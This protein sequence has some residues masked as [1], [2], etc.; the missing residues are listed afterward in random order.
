MNSKNHLEFLI[1]ASRELSSLTEEVA[2]FRYTSETLIRIADGGVT[3]ISTFDKETA[4]LECRYIKG[5]GG[6][7]GKVL[8]ILKQ[9]IVGMRLP[10]NDEAYSGLM[11]SRLHTIEGGLH[12]LALGSLPKK[13][14]L[15]IERL[16]KLQSFYSL[17]IVE[18]NELLGS[19]TL[20]APRPLQNPSLV[21]AFIQQAAPTFLRIRATDALMKANNQ[22][23][24]S[25]FELLKAEKQL[26]EKNKQLEAANQQLEATNQQFEAANRQLEATNQQFEATNQQIEATNQQL[27]TRNLE[28]QESRQQI[29]ENQRLYERV[30][31]NIREALII[32]DGRHILFANQAATRY[33]DSTTLKGQD[34]FCFVAPKS[35]EMISENIRKRLAGEKVPDV[36][37]AEIMTKS[38]EMVPVE[39]SVAAISYKAKKAFLVML[40]DLSEREKAIREKA[41]LQKQLL[42]SQKMEAIATLAGGM[43]HDLNNIL[44]VIK[45]HAQLTLM[46]HVESDNLHEDM[47]QIM[48][49]A[50]RGAD[51]TRQLLLYSRRQ[52]MNYE[53]LNINDRV[54][55]LMKLLGRLIGED[56]KVTTKLSAELWD[57]K[58][59]SGNIDQ[60]I[61]NLTVNARDAM[62]EGGE[63]ILKT[64]N[65]RIDEKYLQSYTYAKVGEHVCLE[66]EDTGTGMDEETTARIFEP[67]FTTKSTGKGTGLGMSVVYGIVKEHGGWINVYSEPGRGS[68]FKVYLP[69]SLHKQ[70]RKIQN[71][72]NVEISP[73]NGENILLVEDEE[74]VLTSTRKLL[75][76]SGYQITVAT[77]AE[78]ALKIFRQR[79]RDFDLV[80]TDTILPGRTGL[81]LI[82]D[83]HAINPNI[84]VLVCSGYTGERIQRE[85]IEKR[86]YPFI[87]KPFDL[88]QLLRKIKKAMNC[89]N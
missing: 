75:E 67:F 10:I 55:S 12:T 65:V 4:D 11:E 2:V 27:E 70:K 54:N 35:Q 87:Q 30:V 48:E 14:S 72:V 40:H 60:V 5:L 89:E 50:N 9:K 78:E 13:I 15:M 45:G 79:E 37:D 58:A 81:E 16:L 25:N 41:T 52:P 64:H 7:S 46:S 63:L 32:H 82:G 6:M 33:V 84:K 38:G 43:A 68:V 17:G 62:P 28:L 73:G 76:E 71:L 61:M 51:L 34:L 47:E 85:T 56:V 1:E 24:A 49:S 83:I 22:L 53:Q 44:T 3:V 57:V 74:S 23:K 59:D 26:K 8:S 77:N 88:D 39:L 86:N 18:S 29:D 80:F 31:E 69:A 21:E 66:I 19:I 42:Q 20:M 36:Y